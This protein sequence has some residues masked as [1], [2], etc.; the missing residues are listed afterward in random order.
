MCRNTGG[1]CNCGTNPRCALSQLSPEEL[2]DASSTRAPSREVSWFHAAR[3]RWRHKRPRDLHDSAVWL[4]GC[5]VSSS[6]GWGEGRVLTIESPHLMVS[7]SSGIAVVESNAIGPTEC[8]RALQ[9]QVRSTNR[10]Q[11]PSSVVQNCLKWTPCISA[12]VH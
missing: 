11:T 12:I 5:T 8:P 1:R 9:V 6:E 4:L 3:C 7:P 2:K 10:T